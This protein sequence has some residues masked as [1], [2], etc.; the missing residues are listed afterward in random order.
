MASRSEELIE[1]GKEIV[2]ALRTKYKVATGNQ[3]AEVSWFSPQVFMIEKGDK[4]FSVTVK[5]I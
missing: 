1:T 5:E 4:H 2:E 3:I